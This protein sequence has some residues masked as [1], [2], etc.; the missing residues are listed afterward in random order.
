MIYVPEKAKLRGLPLHV[1]ECYGKPNVDAFYA[2]NSVK[3]HK[4]KDNALCM[5]CNRLATNVHHNPPLSKG[6]SFLLVG[7]FGTYELKPALFAL[8]GSGTT[9]CHNGFH[10]GATFSAEWMWDNQ[11]FAES[12]WNGSLLLLHKSNSKEL[13]DYGYWLIRDKVTGA[14][15]EVRR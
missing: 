13:F 7:E 2:G 6:K 14:S 10:G 8:C 9:G 1:A 11:K 3:S 12:W 15:F 4:L 5:C